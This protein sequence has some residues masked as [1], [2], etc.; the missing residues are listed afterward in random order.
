MKETIKNA[1]LVIPAVLLLAFLGIMYSIRPVQV[2]GSFLISGIFL[3]VLATYIANSI[4]E[5]ENDV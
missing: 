4:Q 3:F 1:V 2:S 5:K